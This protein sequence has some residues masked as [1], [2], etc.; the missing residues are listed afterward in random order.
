MAPLGSAGRLWAHVD[1]RP[2]TRPRPVLP[3]DE[4]SPSRPLAH[5]ASA[6]RRTSGEQM[7]GA[8]PDVGEKC[9]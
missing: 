4:S 3:A 5:P 9:R 2:P 8:A 6:A 1:A 7:P